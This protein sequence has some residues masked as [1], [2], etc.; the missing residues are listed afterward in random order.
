M[1]RL[2]KT[3]PKILK[4]LPASVLWAPGE[5]TE[6][7]ELTRWELKT[8]AQQRTRFLS[9]EGLLPTRS[10]SQLASPAQGAAGLCAECPPY[11][12]GA[13]SFGEQI[14]PLFLP[15]IF[16]EQ[17]A[18]ASTI[19][20]SGGLEANTSYCCAFSPGPETSSLLANS[21]GPR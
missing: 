5:P 4:M 3:N 6:E 2:Y 13:G 15:C 16:L 20:F 1:P 14:L 8:P 21:S 18:G 9:W 10:D 7:R 11:A 19:A 17:D 12:G